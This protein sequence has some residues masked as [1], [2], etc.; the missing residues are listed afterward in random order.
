MTLPSGADLYPVVEATWSPMRA[1]R[2]GPWMIRD[3]Q[4][5]GSRVSAA[6]AVD[7]VSRADLAVAEAAMADLGQQSLFMIRDGDDALDEMLDGQGYAVKD[8]VALY[9]VD[10][11]RLTGEPLPPVSAM[12]A[13]PP[14]AIMAEIWRSGGIGPARLA[15][16]ERVK[17]PK[18]GLLGRIQDQPAA[19]AFVACDGKVAMIHALEVVPALRRLGVAR[20]MMR[21]AAI[22]AQNH[23]ATTLALAVTRSNVSANAL[24]SSLGMTVVGYYHYRIK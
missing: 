14:L 1:F 23:G 24:Y 18:T 10:V 11:A 22:W 7:A 5:G 6:T 3:G 8:P 12:P 9:A 4:G 20:N 16:M 2:V 19:S 15:V 17:C 21:A 13:W